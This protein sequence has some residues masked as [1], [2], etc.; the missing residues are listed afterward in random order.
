[1]KFNRQ[2]EGDKRCP[3]CNRKVTASAHTVQGFKFGPLC[4]VIVVRRA[5]MREYFASAPREIL[6][7]SATQ[8]RYT[9][10]VES[11]GICPDVQ[12]ASCRYNSK[13]FQSMD[14]CPLELEQARRELANGAV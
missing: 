10:S 2:E 11:K 8:R 5:R 9:A 14:L 7:C 6:T 1:M 3:R 13:A 12:C 4:A